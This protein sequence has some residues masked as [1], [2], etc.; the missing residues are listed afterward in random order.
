MSWLLY[1]YYFPYPY[2]LQEDLIIEGQVISSSDMLCEG[3][4]FFPIYIN[5]Y[6]YVLQKKNNTIFYLRT[7]TNENVN[8]ICYDS[9]DVVP[10]CLRYI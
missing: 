3:D 9:K 10:T 7:I 2:T 4:D 6:Y 8:V 5:S 1:Y